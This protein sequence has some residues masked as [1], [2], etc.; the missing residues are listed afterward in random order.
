MSRLYVKVIKNIS[1]KITNSHQNLTLYECTKPCT[2]YGVLWSLTFELH[3]TLS[4][5]AQISWGIAKIKESE[6]LHPTIPQ[7]SSGNPSDFL[8][9]G[10]TKQV[11]VSGN[12]SVQKR[13]VAMDSPPTMHQEIQVMPIEKGS[14]NSKR[15]MAVGDLVTLAARSDAL[16]GVWIRG[17]I[18]VWVKM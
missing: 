12:N 16:L 5:F 7:T 8:E 3:D 1:V 14:T 18:T 17:Q 4:E 15:R 11:L 10:D 6:L 9:K 2:V 13:R